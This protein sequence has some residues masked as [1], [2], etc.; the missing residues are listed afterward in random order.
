MIQEIADLFFYDKP[1]KRDKWME[2]FRDPLWQP[3]YEAPLS[4]H[5]DLAYKQLKKVA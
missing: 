4:A 5:R 2:L 3:I 1:A